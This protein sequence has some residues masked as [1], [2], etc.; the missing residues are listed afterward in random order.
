MSQGMIS[1]IK[2][3]PSLTFWTPTSKTFILLNERWL[4][5]KVWWLQGPHNTET[6]HAHEANQ[7]GFWGLGACMFFWIYGVVSN[8]PR[9]R[10]GNFWKHWVKGSYWIFQNHFG[11]RDIVFTLTIFLLPSIWWRKHCWEKILLL[12]VVPQAKVPQCTLRINRKHYPK[13]ILKNDKDLRVGDFDYAQSD[14]LSVIKWKDRGKKS[15]NVLTTIHNCKK[16]KSIPEKKYNVQKRSQI[17][18][19]IWEE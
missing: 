16:D 11:I 5:M 19:V 3:D 14:E 13:S 12:V 2:F 10:G 15:V 1:C 9:Q 6:I 8:I 18:I 17:I 7:E 4:S